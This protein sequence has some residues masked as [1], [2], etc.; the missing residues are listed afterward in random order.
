MGRYFSYDQNGDGM[1]FHETA[2]SAKSAAEKALEL[3]R[4]EAGDGGWSEET[5]MI[6]WGEVKEIATQG[7]R[8]PA[9]EGSNYDYTVD[10]TLLE[11]K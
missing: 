11:P 7:E 2:E 5:C 3:E 10:Y 8:S 6:C 1:V 4:D 9:P